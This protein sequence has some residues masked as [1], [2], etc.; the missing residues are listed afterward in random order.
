M[1]KYFRLNGLFD[2]YGALLTERQRALLL[3]YLNEDLSLSEIAEREEISRQGVRDAL[4]RAG[5]QLEAYEAKLGHFSMEARLRKAVN[6]L[7]Q[8]ANGQTM[9]EESRAM[10][11]EA[12]HRIA[13]IVN[14]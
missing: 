12:I 2:C 4:R 8:T 13:G 6:V 11:N 9:D 7:E 1:E 14:E 5:E 10:F 3:Q